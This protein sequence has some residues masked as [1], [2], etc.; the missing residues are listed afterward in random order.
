MS[1]PASSAA[2]GFAIAKA[3]GGLLA[4]GVVASALGFLVMLPKTPREAAAR[5]VATMAGSALVGPLIVAAAYSR[6]P[7]VFAAGGTLA[8]SLGM[9]SWMGTFMVAAPLLA[10]AGLPFWWLLGAVVLWFERR[11]GLDVGQLAADARA[12][13]GKAVGP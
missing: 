11:K 12:D 8:V 6:Y 13:V 5:V 9:E 4:V 3:V 2:G 1:E 10:M 7:E